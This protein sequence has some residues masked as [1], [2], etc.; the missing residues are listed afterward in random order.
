MKFYK[1]IFLILLLIIISLPR[2]NWRPL[3]QPFNSF[4]GQK[5]FD[6]EQYEKYVEFFRG[7]QSLK[8]IL[9]APFSYRPLIPFLSSLLPFDALT[10]IN[11][12]NLIIISLGL[13]FL[14][15]L[16]VNFGFSDKLVTI[17]GLLFVVSFP[18]FYYTTSGY[19]DA[20]LIGIVMISNYFLF[21]DKYH[22]FILFFSLGVLTKETIIILIPVAV[23]FILYNKKAS[24]KLLKILLVIL[25]Y[26]LIES[27]IR[28]LVPAK[29]FYV[30]KP[31]V[32]ILIY[33]LTRFKTYLSF[34]LT[35]GIPGI[36]SLILLLT[37]KRNIIPKEI[38]YA[39]S[40]GMFSGLMLWF[41]SIFSAYADGRQ[42]WIS[43]PF[44]AILSVYFI[45]IYFTKNSSN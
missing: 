43:Y 17:G 33:N 27:A 19:I 1:F 29:N 21:K 6:V 16:L 8:G 28:Y 24:H 10:S 44:A 14:I 45:Q 3:P 9:E 37:N 22:L 20:S 31:S 40:I 30:W 4:V 5:P 7:N 2:F 12:I 13:I 25:I 32:D 41:Y 18:L 36:F 23:V 11:I 35:F 15:K 34:I 39:F 26:I 42:L 38:L